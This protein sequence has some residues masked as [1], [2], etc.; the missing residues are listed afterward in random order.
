[1]NVKPLRRPKR[2]IL[3]MTGGFS[4]LLHI[5]IIV[6][7]ALNPWPTFMKVQPRAYTVTLMSVSLPGPLPVI[8]EELPKPI[9]KPK[10]DDII[11]KVKKPPLKKDLHKLHEA[12]EE[13]RK[14]AALDEIQKRI[15][16]R[17]QVEEK[18]IN[19]S[20]DESIL[21]Q[22]SMLEVNFGQIVESKIKKVWTIPENLVKEIIDLETIIV[23]IIDKGGKIQRSWVEKSSGNNLYDQSAMRAI[24]KAEPFPPIPEVLNKETLE[25]EIRFTP[26]QIR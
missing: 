22:K 13:I 2:S 19:L 12:L 17:K 6:L 9:E 1:M 18:S 4:L 25:I 21:S 8:K 7:F 10:K 20:S 16:R 5:V 14:K 11:E 24:K 3:L 15:D 26:E 23:I